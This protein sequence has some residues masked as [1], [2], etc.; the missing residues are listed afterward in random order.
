MNVCWYDWYTSSSDEMIYLFGRMYG[1]EFRYESVMDGWEWSFVVMRRFILPAQSPA[2]WC[3]CKICW[4]PFNACICPSSA[5]PTRVSSATLWCFF[6][7]VRIVPLYLKCYF[8]PR[9]IFLLCC[10][11]LLK[12]KHVQWTQILSKGIWFTSLKI[13]VWELSVRSSHNSVSSQPVNFF[14]GVVLSVK[15]SVIRLFPLFQGH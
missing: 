10:C 5:L 8:L 4:A 2:R 14:W 11:Q 13:C 3:G 12:W 1:Y 6:L 7:D 9:D 15:K